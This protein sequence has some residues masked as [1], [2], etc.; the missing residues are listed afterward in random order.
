LAVVLD[1]DTRNAFVNL[2]VW[3]TR[4]ADTGDVAFYIR[5]EHRHTHVGETLSQALQS[6]SLTGTGGAGDQAVAV[7]VARVQENLA[8]GAAADKNAIAHVWS[9]YLVGR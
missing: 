8:V 2:G 5:H 7:R 3:L 6:D 4:L 1:A 9:Q